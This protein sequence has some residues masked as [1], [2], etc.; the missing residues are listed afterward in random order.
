MPNLLDATG[1]Q[2]KTRAELVDEFT[3]NYQAIYGADITLSSDS[4]DGQMMNIYIQSILDVQDLLVEIYSSFDPD[5]A[6]GVTLDQRV[7]IN[8]IQRQA[9]T[10]TVT[11]VTVVVSQ[12]LNLY[13]LDQDVQDVFTVSD[14]AGVHWQLV[15]TQLGVVIG[16]HEF[17]FRAAEPGA[18]LTTPNTIT[19][20]ITI[21][22][23]VVS[24][25]NPT[26]YSSLGINEET[27]GV[28]KLRRQKAVSL[29]SQGYLSALQAALENINGVTSAYIYENT[30]GLTDT[31]GIPGHS[32]W[33]IVAGSADDAE[34][35][36]AIYV[37]RNAGCGMYGASSATITQVDGSPFIVYWD[38]V[39]DQNLFV[40]LYRGADFGDCGTGH[41]GDS[42]RARIDAAARRLRLGRHYAAW[43]ARSGYRL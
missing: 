24:V 6:V 8:G 20:P 29:A 3:A 35:G 15:T 39:V 4:P 40:R 37:K 25:N 36:E 1:L 30:T 12:A 27:D 5:N 42:P 13:G 16:T 32:I 22:L 14:N 17:D 34:I 9:G 26:T 38:A 11:P 2:V 10:Y 28:L 7:A 18:V 19:A 31:D 33:V 21:V 43:R 41:C 23:G